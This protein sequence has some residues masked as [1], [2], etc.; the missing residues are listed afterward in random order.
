MTGKEAKS[1][2]PRRT[3]DS[4]VSKC[5][6]RRSLSIRLRFEDLFIADPVVA[7]KELPSLPGWPESEVWADPKGDASANL[8]GE[9]IEAGACADGCRE[10][11]VRPV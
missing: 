8:E 6:E 5:I 10:E 7:K 3:E 11:T 4:C 1:R 2:P 9:G